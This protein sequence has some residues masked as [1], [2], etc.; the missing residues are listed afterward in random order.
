MKKR[1]AGWRLPRRTQRSQASARSPAKEKAS[2]RQKWD[3]ERT[4]WRLPICSL[5][6]RK[7]QIVEAQARLR[8]FPV[9]SSALCVH[10][11]VPSILFVVM[12]R[13]QFAAEF[14]AARRICSLKRAAEKSNKFGPLRNLVRAAQPS[15]FVRSIHFFSLAGL[16]KRRR[17]REKTHSLGEWPPSSSPTTTAERNPWARPTKLS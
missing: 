11:A 3:T 13:V 14:A 17:R 15:H 12:Q 7:L 5:A 16:Q 10:L 6:R 2:Q 8:S 4:R 9:R 1:V